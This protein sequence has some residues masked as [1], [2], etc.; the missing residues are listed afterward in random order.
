MTRTPLALA[1]V[2]LALLS[3]PALAGSCDAD[4]KK[5]DKALS[6]TDLPPDQKAQAKDMRGQAEKLCSAG[7]EEE[8]ADVL[9]EVKAMLA[10][11]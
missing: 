3:A 10:V 9:S 2:L 1:L 8:A 5:I 11:E 4:L 7:N 6:S